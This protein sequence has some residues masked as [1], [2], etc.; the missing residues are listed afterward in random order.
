ME[1]FGWS[2]SAAER[3][4]RSPRS[5][6]PQQIGEKVAVLSCRDDLVYGNGVLVKEDEV[7]MA[8]DKGGSKAVY[9]YMNGAWRM[10]GGSDKTFLMMPLKSK[11][12]IMKGDKECPGVDASH[13]SFSAKDFSNSDFRKVNFSKSVLVDTSFVNTDL[14]L[15]RLGEQSFVTLFFIHP[16]A[17]YY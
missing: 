11:G 2:P 8:E 10:V 13:G 3:E 15:G 16:V 6:R 4:Q 1:I 14:R 5:W 7:D 9:R 12:D 17:G